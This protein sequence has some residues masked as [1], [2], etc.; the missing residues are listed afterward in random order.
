[1]STKIITMEEAVQIARNEILKDPNK[2]KEELNEKI[3]AMIDCYA[4][5]YLHGQSGRSSIL[6]GARDED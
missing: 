2:P 6:E 4:L 5:G 1:M 3:I